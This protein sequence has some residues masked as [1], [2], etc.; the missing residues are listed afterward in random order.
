MGLLGCEGS[1]V[2]QSL[3]HDTSSFLRDAFILGLE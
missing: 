2:E 1:W 3:G